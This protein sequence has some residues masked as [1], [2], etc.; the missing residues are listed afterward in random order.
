MNLAN[1]SL[2]LTDSSEL[3]TLPLVSILI[4]NYNYDLFVGRAIDSA[5]NQTYKNIEVI[6]VDDGSQDKS[7]EIIAGYGSQIIPVFKENGGQ[8][9]NYNEGFA[10]SKGEIICFLDSDDW[11]VENKIEKVVEIF[12]A[13]EENG[14]CFHS[15][16]LVDKDDNIL[17]K[18]SETQDYTTHECDYRRLLKLGKIPPCLPPS[19]ALCF[20]RSILEKVLPMPTPKIITNNDYYVKFMTVA[21]SKGFILGDALT[22][23]K[24]H[25][26][27]AASGMKGRIH[28]KARKF[29]YTGIW[30]KQNF[31][32]FWK[33]ANKLVAL[34][35]GLSWSTGKEDSE[36]SQAIKNYFSFSSLRDRIQVTYIG[37]YYCLKQ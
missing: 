37:W 1:P 33:F 25:G 13:S 15:V 21:L 31:P 9:S 5:L 14:W 19:S 11:F 22:V 8:P 30:I 18:I 3:K 7:R 16:E 23:Q 24:L 12:Q 20:K 6:V 2:S 32:D 34:G 36:N 28:L 17:P 26:N 27:N 29:I 4:G 10:A 35:A